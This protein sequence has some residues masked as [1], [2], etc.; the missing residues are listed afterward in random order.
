VLGHPAICTE[1]CCA[2]ALLA[3]D[4]EPGPAARGL[5]EADGAGRNV[6]A[7]E[8]LRLSHIKVVIIGTF[9]S[10]CRRQSRNGRRKLRLH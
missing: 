6:R 1:G 10:L 3:R 9:S 8:Q 2:G 7:I 5:V 4:V